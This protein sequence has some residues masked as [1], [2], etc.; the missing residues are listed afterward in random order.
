MGRA[1]SAL[2]CSAPGAEN[3]VDADALARRQELLAQSVRQSDLLD[4]EPRA[5][6]CK[7]PA[8]GS[9]RF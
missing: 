1:G 2:G 7:S 4:L 6:V 5:P 8:L 9:G 3:N